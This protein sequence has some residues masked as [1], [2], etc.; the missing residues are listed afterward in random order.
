M[1]SVCWSKRGHHL[2]IGT[3]TGEVQVWDIQAGKMTRVLKGHEGRV[4]TIAWSSNVL[5]SGSRDKNII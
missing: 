1:T 3:N 2:S 5:A 4:G